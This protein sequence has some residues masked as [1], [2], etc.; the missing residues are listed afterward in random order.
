[1]A[2]HVFG[3]IGQFLRIKEQ[4]TEKTE[5]LFID[6]YNNTTK[7]KLPEDYRELAKIRDLVNP[8]QMLNSKHDLH[9]KD[10]DL[11]NIIRATCTE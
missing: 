4:I 11:I 3:D 1:M 9:N 7:N 2:G 8:I 10:R 5:K 6:S